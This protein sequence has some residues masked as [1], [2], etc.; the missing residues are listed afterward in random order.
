MEI[1]TLIPVISGV[2]SAT[3]KIANAILSWRQRKQDQRTQAQATELA[4]PVSYAANDLH[5]LMDV[6]GAYW[7]SNPGMWQALGNEAARLATLYF[8]DCR[9]CA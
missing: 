1:V 7:R 3:V 9:E 6:Q 2:V 8:A 4:Q 5:S